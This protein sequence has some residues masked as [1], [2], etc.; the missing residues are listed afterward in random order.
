MDIHPR[1]LIVDDDAALVGKLRNSLETHGIRAA[2]ATDGA[3]GLALCR[4]HSFDIALINIK[5]PDTGGLDFVKNLRAVSGA[6]DCIIM[7][8]SASLESAIQALREERVTGCE[9]KPLD[10]DRLLAL[11][12]QILH[13]KETE[14]ALRYR[15]DFEKLITTIST[16][17]I[18]LTT[19]EIDR[20]INEA[21]EKIGRF[22]SAD[23][24]YIFRYYSGGTKMDNTHEWCAEGIEPQIHQLKEVP[25]DF[26]PC[27]TAD[28]RRLQV[29]SVPR[30]ADLP[31]EASHEKEEFQR[32]SIQSLVNI[33]MVASGVLTGVVGFDWVREERTCSE[34]II[35]L[36]K[37]VG[38]IFSNALQRKEAE[39]AL[40][41]S[42]RRSKLL[43]DSVQAGIVVVDPQSH[44]IVD[45][46][47]AALKM[48]GAP[49]EDVI[50]RPCTTYLRSASGTECPVAES[51]RAVDNI[52]GLLLMAKGEGTPI[53]KSVVPIMMKGRRHLLESFVDITERKRLEDELRQSQKMK[54]IG[55]LAGGVAHDFNNLLTGILGY[56]DM[57][58]R[59]AEP[60]SEVYKA[61][62]TIEEVADRAA[63]L[64]RQLLGFARKGKYRVIPIDAHETI[65]AVAALLGRTIDKN[66]RIVLRLNAGRSVVMGDPSQMEQMLMNLAFNARDAMPKGG[67]LLFET[68]V[69]HLGTMSA[70]AHPLGLTGAHLLIAVSDTGSGIPWEIQGRV[71]EPF[72]TTKASGKGIGMGLATV[73]G[74]VESHGG[75]IRVQSKENH[76]ATFKIYLP[77]T[78]QKAAAKETEEDKGECVPGSGR[79]LIVDDEEV[80]RNIAAAILSE[81]GYEAIAVSSG[82]EAVERYRV[83]GSEIDLVVLDMVMPEMDGRKC[84]QALKAIDPDV[85]VI[86]ASG[87]GRNERAQ[88]I[89][90]EGA[91]AF[92]P[93][94]FRANELSLA[95]AGAINAGGS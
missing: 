57:L 59:K 64:T 87:Y 53:L 82:K 13:R 40:W 44:A 89:M 27:F 10:T 50:G 45:A 28:L 54:A 48:I 69:V 3:A 37:I 68:S 73:Y 36:L 4:E 65:R 39:E 58:M 56:A 79:I 55:Q 6:T 85:K 19:K 43:L 52:E 86:L 32:E 16:Q 22:A 24:S 72:F 21:L 67:E 71:F 2:G 51:D 84:F 20:G 90:N 91:L 30:V 29:V 70:G 77:L 14:Q 46:N 83:E 78:D 35:A 95:V 88:Q 61:A 18:N 80:V 23:R 92:V 25:V 31:L 5:L 15:L 38:E 75:S 81:L 63:E 76:G 12:R 41:E 33:P 93:K 94:P 1:I 8:D 9:T 74:I 42:E 62:Q 26:F 66:V 49:A 47:T 17:F 7:A 34:D 11:I 60:G